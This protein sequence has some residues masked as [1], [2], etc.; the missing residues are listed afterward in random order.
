MECGGTT[1]LWKPGRGGRGD[2]ERKV[3]M[4]NK[5]IKK[6]LQG[7]VVSNKMDKTVVVEVHR[8]TR[9]P[10]YKKILLKSKRYKAHDQKNECK[11]GDTVRIMECRPLSK[12]KHFRVVEI[13]ERAK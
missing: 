10:L 9:H 11:E 3:V 12:E 7:V 2:A 4:E 8:S 13:T 1:P 5:G 6:T